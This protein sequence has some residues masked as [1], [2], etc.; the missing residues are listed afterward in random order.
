M[1][2]IGKLIKQDWSGS[3]AKWEASIHIV[4]IP[5][6]DGKELPVLVPNRDHPKSRI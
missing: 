5:P 6:I 1:N 4:E 2:G 3:T